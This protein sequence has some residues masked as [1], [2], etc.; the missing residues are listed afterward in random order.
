[1]DK[2]RENMENAGNKTKPRDTLPYLNQLRV[3]V[4][5]SRCTLTLSVITLDVHVDSATT[6]VHVNVFWPAATHP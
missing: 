6:C 4:L 1:M 5:I 3:S 2:K